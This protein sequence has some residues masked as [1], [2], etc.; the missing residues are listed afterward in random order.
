MRSKTDPDSKNWNWL[1]L[2]KPSFQTHHEPTLQISQKEM[3]SLY[4]V[5][6]V[7]R[8]MH[9]NK[10]ETDRSHFE[11]KSYNFIVQAHQKT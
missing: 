9:Q 5:C 3:F 7:V 1:N 2:K 11:F 10:P 8:K 4:F 6:E